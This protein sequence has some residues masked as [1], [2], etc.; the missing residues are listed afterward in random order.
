MPVPAD[1]PVVL[2]Q[3]SMNECI[4][5]WYSIRLMAMNMVNNLKIILLEE[6]YK[7]WKLSRTTNFKISRGPWRMELGG[8]E[9]SETMTFFL[10]SILEARAPL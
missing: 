9:A 8:K 10:F 7:F 3:V 4:Q 2:C 1:H 5:Y 6:K